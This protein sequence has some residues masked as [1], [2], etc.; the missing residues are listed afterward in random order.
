VL[1]VSVKD[2]ELIDINDSKPEAEKAGQASGGA[3]IRTGGQGQDR[4]AGEQ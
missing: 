2:I 4:P 3:E 1:L